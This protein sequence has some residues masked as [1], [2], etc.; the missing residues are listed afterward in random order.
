MDK[1][2][3]RR[4]MIVRESACWDGYGPEEGCMVL[5]LVLVG[6]SGLGVGE[7]LDKRYVYKAS[8][9]D[10]LRKDLLS[11]G[12]NVQTTDELRSIA[13]EL[14]GAIVRV[15]VVKGDEEDAAEKVY[16]EDYFGRDDPSKYKKPRE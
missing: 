12:Y 5:N 4:M 14:V 3:D 15:S 16:I 1:K 13:G 10:C 9:P 11:M 8:P 7:E 2:R 6:M